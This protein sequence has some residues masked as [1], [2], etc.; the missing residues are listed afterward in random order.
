MI[1]CCVGTLCMT[2]FGT[3]FNAIY[4]L[5]AFAALYGM[6]LEIIIE[7]GTKINPRVSGLWSFALLMVTPINLIKGTSV[8][9]I[10]MLI[11]KKLSPVIKYGIGG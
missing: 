2:V 1:G 8:S 6:P 3:A 5:P 10:T 4:L 9:I 11:Y 7:M